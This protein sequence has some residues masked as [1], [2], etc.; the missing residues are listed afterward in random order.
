M[1]KHFAEPKVGDIWFRYYDG[2]DR[3]ELAELT[4]IKVTA[5]C[6]YLYEHPGPEAN[7]HLESIMR[8][9]KR[10]LADPDGR[11]HAYPT[12]ELAANSY[13]I[14]KQHQRKYI[15]AAVKKLDL[16]TLLMGQ[17][18]DIPEQPADS[19]T[20]TFSS[21]EQLDLEEEQVR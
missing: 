7:W 18:G 3:I 14:R 15:E 19:L 11:R 12:R 1:R 17:A 21:S 5:K 4:V 20:F 10:V 13:R 8:F 2:R 16:M 9:A 6:V